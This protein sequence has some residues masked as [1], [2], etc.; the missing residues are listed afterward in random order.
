[1][2]KRWI[3]ILGLLLLTAFSPYR[4]DQNDI[5]LEIRAG[6]EGYFRA[7]KWL[8]VQV[9]VRNSGNDFRG[10]LQVRAQDIGDNAETLYQAPL[11]V[12]RNSPKTV[13]VYVSLED[14]H[15]NIQVELVDTKGRIVETATERLTQLRPRDILQVV[16]TES[17]LGTV[18]VTGRQLGI[19]DT[20]QVNWTVRDIPDEADA[21]R[22]VDVITL[23]DIRN[24]RL[25]REQQDA[26]AA[27]VYSGG[28]LILHGGPNWQYTADFFN[29]L[30]PT[31]PES[32]T[33]VESFAALGAYLG[34][35][36]DTLDPSENP[37]VVTA[38]T[39]HD[40]AEVLVQVED[41]PLIVRAL[42]GSG[43]VDFI[44]ADPMTEPLNTYQDLD[45]L[46]FNLV[47][48]SPPRPSW[49]Y[50]FED[51][52]TANRAIRIISGYDF[53]SALQ[54]LA[55]LGVYIV[56]IGPVN[57]LV[58]RQVRRLEL[59]W[60]TIP[61]LIAIF[62]AVAYNTGFS[63]RGDAPTVSHLSVVQVWP[64]SDIARVDGLVGVFSPRRTTYDL[65]IP[66]A[67]TLRTVPGI[68][69][70][71]TAIAEIPIVQDEN[72]R[73]TDLP[74]DA[75]V[76]ATFATS[77]YA[78]AT[79]IEGNAV[80]TL[81]ETQI[82]QLSG[83]VTNTTDFV[84]E[85]AVLLAKDTYN[86][87]GQLEPGA[88]RQFKMLVEL[89]EPTWLPI[90][91]RS[92][93][94]VYFNT[95]PGRPNRATT[96]DLNPFGCSD[97]GG[98][99]AMMAEVMVGQDFD[100]NDGRGTEEQREARRRALLVA[101]ISS[102]F[103][104]SGGRAG[105]V[106]LVGWANTAPF[107][108]QLDGDDQN[109]KYE[110][111]YIFKLPARYATDVTADQPILIPPGLLTWTAIDTVGFTRERTPY[112]L[113]LYNSEQITFRF[114]P[115]GALANLAIDR[116]DLFIEILGSSQGIN[117]AFWDWQQGIW[118]VQRL[119]RNQRQISLETPDA[120]L[121]PDNALLV[122][123]LTDDSVDDG[124]PI[125]YIEPFMYTQ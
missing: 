105:D 42:R 77:G 7:G 35:P 56:L 12:A 58:L 110:S 33:T 67:M 74:V 18:D 54:M 80:W 87:I 10:T 62:T 116:I 112:N 113:R 29:P 17:P 23:F 41:V 70:I 32:L 47:V 68:K 45:T 31:T 8:P 92:P 103:D 108:A 16:L 100:C 22:A 75:G 125:Q 106:Y 9:T 89:Q 28:H 63:L 20:I 21:L 36:S 93:V 52:T 44:A 64:D 121:G 109:N 53:P 85:D 1:M 73:V 78:P 3:L 65:S 37:Y 34:R 57:Y 94:N 59:A 124:P 81:T 79:H 118:V 72:Y 102:E 60:F 117:V 30:L 107:T 24:G 5:E 38:N 66:D 86:P 55:F 114:A 111:L 6:Y 76:V 119:D 61:L 88:S 51:W 2:R 83:Q 91:N 11:T 122:Q 25:S 4:Q 49:D 123:V 27:W 115:V 39:P 97:I 40:D 82:V 84:L 99:D 96:Y 69:D 90:G 43:V 95:L 71:D 50:D 104:Y 13:F 98:Y 46:W 15:P 48:S 26:L 19:G 14:Q 101:S 120:Y